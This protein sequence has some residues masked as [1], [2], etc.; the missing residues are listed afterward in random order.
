[1]RRFGVSSR[2][3]IL[4][5]LMWSDY[6]NSMD[7]LLRL[8][9]VCKRKQRDKQFAA[10]RPERMVNAFMQE[11]GNATPPPETEAFLSALVGKFIMVHTLVSGLG[12]SAGYRGSQADDIYGRLESNY[13]DA[14]VLDT[15]KHGQPTGGRILVFKRAIVAI[16]IYAV[17][18]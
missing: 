2:L 11:Q 5:Q 18:P 9:P 7:A 15:I 4:P 13:P 17:S 16:E 3:A 14:I 6:H 8:V 1:M 10:K 12:T